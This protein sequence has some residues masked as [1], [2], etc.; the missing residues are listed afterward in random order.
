MGQDQN[1]IVG[2]IKARKAEFSVV[3]T[4]DSARKLENL[5]PVLFPMRLNPHSMMK[6]FPVSCSVDK[7]HPR[8]P[9]TVP[10]FPIKGLYCPYIG[11]L[12]R[13]LLKEFTEYLHSHGSESMVQDCKTYQ[14]MSYTIVSF[15]SEDT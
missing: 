1:N 5:I 2:P 8:I 10:R 3:L 13:Y 7:I 12:V 14:L 15:G 11:S 6:K 4:R 9:R